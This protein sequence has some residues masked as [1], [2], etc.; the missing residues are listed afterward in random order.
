M[1]TGRMMEKSSH[2]RLTTPFTIFVG[3][4]PTWKWDAML[5]ISSSVSGEKQ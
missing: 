2:V 4:K 1:N 5:R 3:P